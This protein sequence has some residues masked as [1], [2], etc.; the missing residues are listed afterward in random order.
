[1]NKNIYE[2]VDNEILSKDELLEKLNVLIGTSLAGL[3]L[4]TRSKVI[5]TH[6]CNA[7]G[8]DVPANFL[9]TRPKFP[10]QNFDIYVQKSNNL[11]IWNDEISNERRYVLMKLDENDCISKIKIIDG[12]QL[13][14]LD[15][16]GKL[17]IKYQARVPE[18]YTSTK[19]NDSPELSVLNSDI[20]LSAISPVDHPEEGK[21]MSINVLHK[22]LQ[23]L[24]GKS[25]I[26]DSIVKERTRADFA[27]KLVCEALGYNTFHDDGQF[28]DI[29]QQLLEV[30][31]QTSPTIDLG[32]HKPD[33]ENKIGICL[34]K[35]TVL[36]SMCRYAILSA[37]RENDTITIDDV[38]VVS[39]KNFFDIFEIFG[40]MVKNAKIQIPLPSNFF[41]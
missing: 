14:E 6:I 19:T 18:K 41:D 9:K 37:H 27:H 4:R 24:K 23:T 30:K 3:P 13:Q 28:P 5:K 25:F 39:G 1:M 29:K 31:L 10:C 20:D 11:Q 26:D 33:E 22:K 34:N 12:L 35:K 38:F 40:G 16:T 36:T 2:V 7:L 15:T 21:L 8:Y 17:T 32:L